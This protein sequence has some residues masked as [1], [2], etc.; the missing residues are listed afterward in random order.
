M[1]NFILCI[2]CHI[3]KK[4]TDVAGWCELDWDWKGEEIGNQFRG[5]CLKPR[6]RDRKK[7]EGVYQGGI[8]RIWHLLDTGLMGQE[9]EMPWRF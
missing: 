9:P 2:F 5:V 6:E 1:V 7:R 3:K 4:N 8:S